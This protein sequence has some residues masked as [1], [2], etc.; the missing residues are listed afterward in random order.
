MEVTVIAKGLE[1]FG[2]KFSGVYVVKACRHE[3]GGEGKYQTSFDVRRGDI[4]EVPS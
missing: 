1:P 4:T 3:I 2:E